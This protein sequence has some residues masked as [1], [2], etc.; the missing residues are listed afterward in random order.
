MNRTT[1]PNPHDPDKT[2]IRCQLNEDDVR[3]WI[4]TTGIN[5]PPVGFRP[6]LRCTGN[7]MEMG[8]EPIPTGQT[9]AIKVPDGGDNLDGKTEA[10]LQTLCAMKSIKYTKSD[11]KVAL[12]QLLRSKP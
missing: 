1:T 5:H 7:V 11:N 9:G 10:E 3:T 4:G 12:I 6:F 2:I 8:I